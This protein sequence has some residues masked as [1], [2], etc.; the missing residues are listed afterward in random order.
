[1]SIGT[2]MDL[3][4]YH[5]EFG[6]YMTQNPLGDRADFVTSPEISQMFAEVLCL[7]A[8]ERY[9]EFQKPARL[10]ILE[11]GPGRG[12]LMSDFLKFAQRFPDFYASLEIHLIEISPTLKNIQQTQLTHLHQ[13]W[14]TDIEDAFKKI[15]CLPTL[16]LANEFF[17]ALPL[18]QYRQQDHH[19][20]QRYVGLNAQK[21]LEFCFKD[22]APKDLPDEIKSCVW[23]DNEIVEVN[24]NAINIIGKI[25]KHLRSVFGAAL[26]ID[27]GYVTGQGDSLQGISQHKYVDVLDQIGEI[28][29]TAHVNFG[30]FQKIAGN[31]GKMI[32]QRDFLFK[33][34]LLDLAQ[35]YGR[36]TDAKTR[37]QIEQQVYK[38]TSSQ[39]MGTLFKVLEL[40]FSSYKSQKDA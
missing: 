27:Y 24:S 7:W 33:Y 21:E 9:L 11:L 6:Y 29:L 23:K 19:W 20:Q 39:E 37:H 10:A 2:L 5:P 8:M 38:L 34:G 1:M 4:L 14:H 35:N 13:F 17:D 12:L 32:T 36:K 18:E 30:H 31:A 15:D 3:A 16:I 28:D 26:L 22:I 25:V 40:N